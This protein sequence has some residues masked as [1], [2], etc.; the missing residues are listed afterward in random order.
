MDLGS[1]GQSFALR[2]GGV[3][4]FGGGGTMRVGVVWLVVF[5]NLAT[6]CGH[7]SMMLVVAVWALCVHWAAFVQ[8]SEAVICVVVGCTDSAS[9]GALHFSL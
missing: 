9:G 3:A 1:V 7:R 2:G 8:L 4:W 5:C 6:L